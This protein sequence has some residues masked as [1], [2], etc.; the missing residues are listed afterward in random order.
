MTIMIADKVSCSK[1]KSLIFYQTYNFPLHF[2]TQKWQK[3]RK[4][5][6]YFPYFLAAEAWT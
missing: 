6:K 4:S 3:K 5:T 2:P 1:T